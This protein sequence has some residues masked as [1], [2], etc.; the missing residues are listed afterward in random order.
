MYQFTSIDNHFKNII[1]ES[2]K[3][4]FKNIQ[5]ENKDKF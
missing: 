4:L 3:I 5:K 2:K 1:F